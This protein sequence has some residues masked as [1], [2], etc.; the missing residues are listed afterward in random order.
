ME[1]G[2]VCL[3]VK[4]AVGFELYYLK[5]KKEKHVRSLDDM[6]PEIVDILRRPKYVELLNEYKTSLFDTSSI[7]YL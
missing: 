6:R 4:T 2:D 5:D 7:L 3:P 1:A